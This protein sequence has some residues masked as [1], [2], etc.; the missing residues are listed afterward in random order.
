MSKTKK[1][2]RGQSMVEYVVVS[3]ALALTLG[4]GM[5]DEQSVLRVFLEALRVAYERTSFSISQPF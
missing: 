4:I 5:R 3:V 1:F 2:Q